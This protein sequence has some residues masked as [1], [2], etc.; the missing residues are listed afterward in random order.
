MVS[1]KYR[2]DLN[3]GAQAF[4]LDI[5][6]PPFEFTTKVEISL[7]PAQEARIIQAIKGGMMADYADPADKSPA[8]S[9]PGYAESAKTTYHPGE[10]IDVLLPVFPFQ[11]GGSATFTAEYFDVEEIHQ[12]DSL[13]WEPNFTGHGLLILKV[14]LRCPHG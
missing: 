14:K 1:Y 10:D 13:V 3:K 6:I 11:E 9:L 7:D 8:F 4:N 5:E 2:D 12:G